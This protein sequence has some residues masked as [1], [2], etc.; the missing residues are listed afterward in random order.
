MNMT[1]TA[2]IKSLEH[3]KTELDAQIE[4]EAHR[5]MPNFAAIQELKR[6]KL[7]V[8]EKIY[9]LVNQRPQELDCA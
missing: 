7:R 9:S 1:L 2:H 4:S 8:K 6:K 5:P 3:R